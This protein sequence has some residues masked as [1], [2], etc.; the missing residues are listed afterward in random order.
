MGYVSAVSVGTGRGEIRSVEIILSGDTNNREQR[1]ASGISERRSHPAQHRRFTDGAHGPLRRQPLAR[2]MGKRRDEFR[3]F[4]NRG[5]LDGCG[6]VTAE[7]LPHD[8][9]AARERR[10]AKGLIMIARVRRTNGRSQRLL[11]I[12]EFRLRFRQC[13]R[14]RP[15]DSLD[16]CIARRQ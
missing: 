3:L 11:R 14:D 8:I 15:M 2:R 16:R 5:R 13:R 10:I 1:V 12:G 6:F 4:V 7:R 9:E